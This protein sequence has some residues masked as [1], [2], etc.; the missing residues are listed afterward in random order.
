MKKAWVKSLNENF[1]YWAPLALWAWEMT[2][3]ELAWAYSVFANLWNKVEINPIQK[4][5]DSRWLVIEEK[6]QSAWNKVLDENGKLKKKRIKHANSHNYEDTSWSSFVSKLQWKSR[7][8]DCQVVKVGKWYPSSQTCHCCGFKYPLVAKKHLENWTCPN[9]GENH[10]RDKNAA[11]NIRNEALKVLSEG[12]E[13]L[14][15]SESLSKDTDCSQQEVSVLAEL[16]LAF[17]K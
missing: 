17:S 14:E 1:Y 2:P 8:Y 7:L 6:K 9:C 11:I 12:Q 15:K 10:Q 5:L 4:I 3:L 13:N 16:A